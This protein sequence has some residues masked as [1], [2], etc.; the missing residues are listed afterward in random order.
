MYQFIRTVHVRH[1]ASMPAA[2]R[3]AALVCGHI[4]KTYPPY[5]MR[6]GTEV[7]GA[8]CLHFFIEF[9]SA[10]KALQMNRSLLADKDYQ[11]LLESARELWVDG[12]MRDRLLVI[13]ST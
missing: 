9:D 8:A 1:A 11:G 10:D 7:F 5:R 12:Q 4:Q 6:Y 2:H 3:F 13:Q